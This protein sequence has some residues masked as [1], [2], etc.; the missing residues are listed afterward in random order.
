MLLEGLIQRWSIPPALYSDRHA[1]FKH[2]ACQPETA[3]EATQFTRGLQELGIQ[4]I[5]ARSPQAKEPVS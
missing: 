3:A 4:L 1:V 2:N 5:F